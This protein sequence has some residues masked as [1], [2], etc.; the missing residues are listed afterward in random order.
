MEIVGLS[1]S[2]YNLLVLSVYLNSIKLFPFY[3]CHGSENL[4]T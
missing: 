3:P 2:Y 1:W 4:M